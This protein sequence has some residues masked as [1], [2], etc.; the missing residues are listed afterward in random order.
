MLVADGDLADQ[1]LGAV[2]PSASIDVAADLA[3]GLARLEVE[4]IRRT[5]LLA[6]ADDDD[7]RPTRAHPEDP[8]PVLIAVHA[9]AGPATEH[10]LAAI[11]AGAARLGIAL[12]GLGSTQRA[13]RL[14]ID[15]ESRVTE[16][17]GVEGWQGRPLYRLTRD[18]ASALVAST[19]AAQGHP[20]AE[21]VEPE[22]APFTAPA[23][24]DRA[25]ID[26][27]VFGPVRVVVAGQEIRTGLRAKARE[28]LAFLATQPDGVTWEAAVDAL[29]PDADAHRGNDRFR[30]V[31]A[32]IRTLRDKL[33]SGDATIVERVGDR[34]RL[35]ADAV[36]CDLW[37]FQR[38]L[39]IA[40]H[41]SDDEAV[42]RA[43]QDAAG[44]YRGDFCDGSYY[45]WAEPIREDLRRRGLDALVR[46]ADIEESSGD[47]NAAVS[48]LERA[49]ELDPYAQS[50]HQRL[51]ELY[52]RLGRQDAAR[53]TYARLERRLAEIDVDPEEQT[54]SAL[55][56]AL[57]ESPRRLRS[58]TDS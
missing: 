48:T 21:A 29:W 53:R 5:R 32:N 13:R 34:Y 30:T 57:E 22:P 45:D 10:R 12:V 54:T 35:N 23:A 44:L 16:A 43:L 28:L 20:S 2:G 46:V 6:E 38:A 40:A 41:S 3:A 15:G 51:I 39:D 1:L 42:A 26:I 8:L 33:D 31:L 25:A 9:S 24:N 58:V 19:A 27:G 36:S 37:H 52:G 17:V 14:V 47:A 18:E 56:R 7:F 55:K 4:T 50:V 49:V 11:E